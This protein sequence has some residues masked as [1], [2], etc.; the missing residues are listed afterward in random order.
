ME[1][2]EGFKVAAERKDPDKCSDWERKN[3]MKSPTGHVLKLKLTLPKGL[4]PAK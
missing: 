1:T 2:P 3:A 4:N